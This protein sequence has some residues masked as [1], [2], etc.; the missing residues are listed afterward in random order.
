MI[1]Q[2]QKIAQDKKTRAMRR[3]DFRRG[4]HRFFSRLRPILITTIIAMIPMG[5]TDYAGAL[6]APFHVAS[7]Y[8]R[9]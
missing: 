8:I 5:D 6:G 3:N 1:P 2:S 7:S 4:W 9:Q